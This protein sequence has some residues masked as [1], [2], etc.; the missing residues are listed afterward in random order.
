MASNSTIQVENALRNFQAHPS[1]QISGSIL[2]WDPLLYM[3]HTAIR[4]DY[5]PTLKTHS[6]LAPMKL[7]PFERVSQNF[8]SLFLHILS[9]LLL[10]SLLF[11][12]GVA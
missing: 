12:V 7:M 5:I 10:F 1:C 2:S 6:F 3:V 8:S 11:T 4:L 9:Q